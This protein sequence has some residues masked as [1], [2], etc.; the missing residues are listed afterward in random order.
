MR[1]EGFQALMHQLVRRSRTDAAGQRHETASGSR[2]TAAGGSVS[3][4]A[5]AHAVPA[6]LERVVRLAAALLD[7]PV[8]SVS[9]LTG[10]RLDGGGVLLRS[11]GGDVLGTLCVDTVGLR[12]W[13][14]A[15]TT[16]LE[17]LSE[18]AALELELRADL[19]SA[20]E[21]DPV[22]GLP[23]GSS[24]ELLISEAQL[25]AQARDC[26]VAVLVVELINLPLVV[27]GLGRVAGDHLIAQVA[28]RLHNELRDIAVGH[29]GAERFVIISDQRDEHATLALADRV[30]GAL[31]EPVI[32]NGWPLPLVSCIGIALG[33]PGDEPAEL[34]DTA[35]AALSGAR[36]APRDVRGAGLE[37][38]RERATRRLGLDTALRRAVESEE[39]V[40]HF[41][42]LYDLR[43]GTLSGFEALARWD[44]PELGP[45]PPTD[46]IPI[47]EASGLIV[48]LG[49]Q[50]LETACTEAAAW[51]RRT[52]G[53]GP[54]VSVNVSPAQLGPALPREVAEVLQTTG[55]APKRLTLEL[56]ES[57]LVSAD[58][59]S[60][61]VLSE[62]RA[63]GVHLALDDFGTGFASLNHLARLPLDVIK[64]DRSF[65]QRLHEPRMHAIV[66][67][68]IAMAN[69]LE[70]SV[71]AEGIETDDLRQEVTELG[72]T[73]GQ[74][75]GL[76]RP[77]DAAAARALAAEA[78]G[79]RTL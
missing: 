65:V 58:G 33:A 76:G 77:A 31:S 30:R 8:S 79:E 13:T 66:T 18:V 44:S 1:D 11:R 73:H 70:L 29:L 67:A 63:L 12:T 69:H 59:V 72:C 50:V 37:S 40:V 36:S 22:S 78:A 19:R 5:Q 2:G 38:V 27:D 46:F 54:G 25:I 62:L 7:V 75:Y 32:I 14:A 28:R 60:S 48:V 49:R 26:A 9:V 64:I 47:A 17:Q 42:P 52:D 55:L 57:A 61:G 23:N 71:T 51:A 43:R 10:E 16:V 3:R 6:A 34:I 68:T 74:G 53:G 56:T 35:V 15:D 21:R 45:V 24:C 39:F 4:P 20:S 41:Q